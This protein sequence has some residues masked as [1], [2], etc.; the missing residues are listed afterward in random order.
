M[1]RRGS[2]GPTYAELKFVLGR[3]FELAEAGIPPSPGS[4]CVLVSQLNRQGAVV[5]SAVDVQDP[6]SLAAAL[7]GYEDFTLRPLLVTT[8]E[9]TLVSAPIAISLVFPGEVSMGH[10]R[11][12]RKSVRGVFRLEHSSAR[13]ILQQRRELLAA[14]QDKAQRGEILEG[15]VKSI[16]ADL[17]MFASDRASSPPRVS[18]LTQP[19]QQQFE[20]GEEKGA[21]K[22]IRSMILS[23]SSECGG[24]QGRGSGNPSTPQPLLPVYVS[25]CRRKHRRGGLKKASEDSVHFPPD[26]F[27]I[28]TQVDVL[29]L[30]VLYLCKLLTSE[31]LLVW[32]FRSV[33]AREGKMKSVVRELTTVS[34]WRL[35][36]EEEGNLSTEQKALVD[37]YFQRVAQKGEGGSTGNS[38]GTADESHRRSLVLEPFEEA[39]KRPEQVS[40]PLM[41][42]QDGQE[43]AVRVLRVL[44][45]GT[46]GIVLLVSLED[47]T[48][49]AL[50]VSY[51]RGSIDQEAAIIHALQGSSGMSEKDEEEETAELARK[52]VGLTGVAT[53]SAGRVFMNEV[54]DVIETGRQVL[55]GMVP[56]CTVDR[57]GSVEVCV[58]KVR[59]SLYILPLEL[60][61]GVSLESLLLSGNSVTRSKLVGNVPLLLG[62]ARRVL[63]YLYFLSSRGVVHGD[64]NPGQILVELPKGYE[65]SQEEISEP[66]SDTES[67]SD[68]GGEGEQE[69]G[70]EG[71]DEAANAAPE[72]VSANEGV[73]ETGS[74]VVGQAAGVA[75]AGVTVETAVG[76]EDGAGSDGD[77]EGEKKEDADEEQEGEQKEKGKQVGEF[78]YIPMDDQTFPE[79][80]TELITEL[81]DGPRKDFLTAAVPAE[82][83]EDVN[84]SVRVLDLGRAQRLS[85]SPTEPWISRG[86]GL[87]YAGART[88]EGWALL[89]NSPDE[90]LV[91]L[92]V[93]LFWSLFGEKLLDL[94][95][96]LIPNSRTAAPLAALVWC[97]VL[98][99]QEE[100]LDFA[101]LLQWQQKLLRACARDVD[102]KA[103]GLPEDASDVEVENALFGGGVFNE[104]KCVSAALE[105]QKPGEKE[106]GAESSEGDEGQQPAAA[107][108]AAAAAAS[109]QEGHRSCSQ[110]ESSIWFRVRDAVRSV[111][112]VSERVSSFFEKMQSLNDSFE[113]GMFTDDQEFRQ[114]AVIGQRGREMIRAQVRL[115]VDEILIPVLHPVKRWDF[116]TPGSVQTF[117]SELLRL[118]HVTVRRQRA[119]VREASVFR[120]K[121]IVVRCNVWGSLF[122]VSSTFGCMLWGIFNLFC[123]WSAVVP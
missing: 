89:S 105:L 29:A 108:A 60:A 57:S 72:G 46:T 50:K 70:G 51:L 45:D 78:G 67:L 69:G 9:R 73:G 36:F 109:S 17:D 68:L 16:E 116:A 27:P 96:D 18:R 113:C 8:T 7:F 92:G 59:F 30:L 2:G 41:I 80:D 26:G 84:V 37:R 3:A 19:L 86:V 97:R 47:G 99:S 82:L 54:G 28:E 111:K 5:V 10:F 38:A 102:R 115:F 119:A 117:R 58:G 65:D 11:K 44:G 112:S 40:V 13:A 1:P 114:N 20:R 12:F 49:T 118:T 32:K 74:I 76:I 66:P 42:R 85:P 62:I 34:R 87:T 110:G 122:R 106:E 95:W 93:N 23:S 43:N 100:R 75:A 103:V 91:F 25:R 35:F 33:E 71:G 90:D 107:A 39:L 53:K 81:A 6:K 104:D 94:P 56:D 15:M 4:G 120:R 55:V 64:L 21:S 24:A 63:A 101:N 22:W 52:V 98:S 88:L 123:V 79:D 31:S 83:Q 121:E 14:A 77:G 48:R 61:Q